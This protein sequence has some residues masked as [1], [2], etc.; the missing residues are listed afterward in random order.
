M[1]T[2]TE[3]EQAVAKH[4]NEGIFDYEAARLPVHQPVEFAMTS[5]YLQRHVSINA[6]VVDVGVGVGHYA[7]LLARR[8]CSI[9]LTDISERL[10]YTA[11]ARLPPAGLADRIIDVVSACATHLPHIE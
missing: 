4:Y 2:L 1:D 5:R 10:L 8:G 6:V 9:H 11:A 7:E 3:R